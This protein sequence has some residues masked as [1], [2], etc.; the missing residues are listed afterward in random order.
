MELQRLVTLV[1]SS[2]M[3]RGIGHRICAGQPVAGEPPLHHADP[4]GLRLREEGGHGLHHPRLRPRSLPVSAQ[5][6]LWQEN[7]R[8]TMRIL[9]DFG[10]GKREAMDSIIRDSVLDLCRF[11]EENQLRPL[12]LGPRLNVA[13]LNVIWKMTADKQFPHG[14]SRMQYFMKSLMEVFKDSSY[15]GN[16]QWVPLLVYLW[17]PALR[18]SRRID[19]NAAAIAK[20]FSVWFSLYDGSTGG[21]NDYI[22]AYLTEMAQQKAR[23]EIN[24]NFSDRAAS[25]HLRP[26]H[27]RERDDN[28]HHP[29]VR[30]VSPLPSRNSG[31]TPGRSRQRGRARPTSFARRCETTTNTI[32]WCVLFLLCHPEIQEK[33]QAEVDSVV[34]P[35]RL[36][37][38]DDRDRMPY[39]QA[40]IMEVQRLANLLPFGLPHFATE[41]IEVAGHR[42]PKGTS[43]L[44]NVWSCHM[45][46]KFWPDP[47][48]FDPGRFLNPDG[49]V[50]TKVPSFLPFL[51]GKRQCL[52]ESLALMELF[53][54]LAIFMQKFTFRTTT[55]HPHPKARQCLGESLALM[56]LFL[57]LAIFMQ[58]FTFRTT[59]GRPHPKAEAVGGLIVNPPKPFQFLVEERKH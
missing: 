11:L 57:F 10:F 15:I 6:S 5:G 26:V 41:D 33:L 19:R 48:K 32:R 9:K 56:E 28:K 23:G 44:A 21:S 58:K 17:P 37:S 34:G 52:G 40:F 1:N 39:M 36:P 46:P 12:D 51:L 29:L 49:S 7:R 35:D 42:F 24:P 54:F 18:A 38:L 53:L 55:G 16:F 27:R 14:D 4:E 13:V 50:K 8:F 47:E 25:D 20:I 30:P 31:E 59:T 22:D 2:Q 3:I 45:D 43:F